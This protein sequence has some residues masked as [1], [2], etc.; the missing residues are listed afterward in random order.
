MSSSFSRITN[1]NASKL[2]RVILIHRHGDRC[3][4]IFGSQDVKET[5][6]WL[7][8]LNPDSVDK[9]ILAKF[10]INSKHPES[11]KQ[12]EPPVGRLTQ[13]G[14]Q[15]LTSLGE[16]I[17]SRYLNITTHP[18]VWSSNYHRTVQSA[19][20][21]LHGLQAAAGTQIRVRKEN[22]CVIDPF[23]RYKRIHE[24][25]AEMAKSNLFHE[26]EVTHRLDTVRNELSAMPCFNFEP[27]LEATHDATK[28][29]SKLVSPKPFQWFH[30]VDVLTCHDRHP[31]VHKPSA[32]AKLMPNTAVCEQYMLW[33]FLEYY[34]NKEVLRLSCGDLLSELMQLERS[35]EEE[36][37][38]EKREERREKEVPL[39][40]FSGHDVTVFPLAIA[41]GHRWT[42]W[43]GYA[44]HLVVEVY[45]DD[46]DDEESTRF[47]VL[48]N[49]GARNQ[50][51]SG[52]G[53]GDGD[54]AAGLAQDE[55]TVIG[56]F[57]GWSEFN[58]ILADVMAGECD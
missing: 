45:E 56:D 52:R 13:R 24:V 16:A 11:P 26:H 8:K 50:N 7:K 30:A 3:P 29:S 9:S 38:E 41:F 5:K 47:R 51:G 22:E 25:T 53:D 23:S 44:C 36:K 12:T 18:T 31:D 49:E 27:F 34:K 2:Q 4:G 42:E 37:R 35:I 32:I 17:K 40:V 43:P 28:V 1:I 33:R 6:S 15:Q 10:P 58:Q 14:A 57:Y 19:G 54:G 20:Y 39:T 21:F 48:L 55:L 46:E